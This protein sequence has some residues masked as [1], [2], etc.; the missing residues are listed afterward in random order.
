MV[1]NL[2]FGWS[3]NREERNTNLKICQIWLPKLARKMP[4][5]SS[6]SPC[7]RCLPTSQQLARLNMA[8][9]DVSFPLF[10]IV[11]IRKRCGFPLRKMNQQ[12]SSCCKQPSCKLC[13]VT[14]L[15]NPHP[16]YSKCF[17]PKI[18]AHLQCLGPYNFVFTLSANKLHCNVSNFGIKMSLFFK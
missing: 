11:V 5:F 14:T 12:T 7:S 8:E 6:S 15:T 2:V 3:S 10:R 17:P 9:Q 4:S 16:V 1:R 18:S 13:D